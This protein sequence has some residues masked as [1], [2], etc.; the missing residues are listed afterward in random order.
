MLSGRDAGAGGR[1]ARV[2]LV[3]E[4]PPQHG[5][6]RSLALL[7]GGG[8]PC[9]GHTA[10][11]VALRRQLRASEGGGVRGQGGRQRR[12]RDGLD[13]R[14]LSAPPSAL[15]P[16]SYDR[17]VWRSDFVAELL[18]PLLLCIAVLRRRCFC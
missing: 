2:G 7:C 12:V 16:C 4:L 18:L 8:G 3:R 9:R 15:P 1:A 5:V 13:A 14:C 10:A 11:P 17:A 6:E